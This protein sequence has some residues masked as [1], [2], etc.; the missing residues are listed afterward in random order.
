MTSKKIKKIPLPDLII[1]LRVSQ[2]ELLKRNESRLEA[3]DKI[4]LGK[5]IILDR[6]HDYDKLINN[7]PEDIQKRVFIIDADRSKTSIQREITKLI[8]NQFK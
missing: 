8:V 3:K 6:Y 7:L 2:K 5:K 1:V 4:R